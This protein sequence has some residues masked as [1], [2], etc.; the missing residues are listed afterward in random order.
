V[1]PPSSLIM[2]KEVM[3]MPLMGPNCLC[4]GYSPSSC[5]CAQRPGVYIY[6]P[7]CI[8]RANQGGWQGLGWVWGRGRLPPYGPLL[9][10]AIGYWACFCRST[11]QHIRASVCHVHICAVRSNRCGDRHWAGAVPPALFVLFSAGSADSL[12]LHWPAVCALI[13]GY[14]S[15]NIYRLHRLSVNDWTS[16]VLRRQRLR[17]RRHPQRCC[18]YY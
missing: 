11:K 14:H 15:P 3:L 5:R 2:L 16:R 9:L 8:N 7:I 1:Q 13:R 17:D 6:M 4:S 12:G 10:L 18:H